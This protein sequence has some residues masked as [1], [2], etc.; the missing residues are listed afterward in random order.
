VPNHG[1]DHS[2]RSSAKPRGVVIG[3][4]DGYVHYLAANGK[5]RMK[6]NTGDEVQHVLAADMDA[7]GRDEILAGSLSHYLYCFGADG[8]R[9]WAVDLGGPIS[10]LSAVRTAGG[11]SLVAVG[12]ATGRVVT[13]DNDGA[14]L[15]ASDL[16]KPV[17]AMLT[18]N[19]TVLVATEDGKLYRLKVE[20]AGL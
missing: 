19:A 3:G 5:L 15:A 20:G 7:D 8:T 17:V 12:T 16:G 6:Y 13:L 11:P 10:A 9:R 1:S 4:G 14:I 18:D 2:P